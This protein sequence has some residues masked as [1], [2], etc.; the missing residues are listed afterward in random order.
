MVKLTVAPPLSLPA[1]CYK[2]RLWWVKEH[3]FKRNCQSVTPH[4]DL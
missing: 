4:A 3:P 1:R 2:C